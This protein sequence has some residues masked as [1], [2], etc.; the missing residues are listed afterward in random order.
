MSWEAFL[1]PRKPISL[2]SS[3]SQNHRL[4]TFLVSCHPKTGLERGTEVRAWKLRNHL[5]LLASLSQSSMWDRVMLIHSK[6]I[7]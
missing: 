2:L 7:S 1:V 3:R 4:P 5:S 6:N